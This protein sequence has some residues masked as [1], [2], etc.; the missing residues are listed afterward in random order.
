MSNSLWPHGLQYTRLP[1]PLYTRLPCPPLSPWVCSSS[2]P[3]SQWCYLNISSSTAPFSF[4]FQSFLTSV[5]SNEST[6]CIRWPKYWSFRFI[7]QFILPVNIQ[8]WFPLGMTH[9]ISLLSKG[10]SRVFFDTTV[11]KHH[12]SVLGLLYDPSLTSMHDY[13][14]NDSFD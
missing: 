10:L 3:L 9:L 12:S 2:C 13:W 4:C 7:L 6:F 11:L 14:K 1:C 8:G 5:I